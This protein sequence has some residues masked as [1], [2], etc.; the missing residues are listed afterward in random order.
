MLKSFADKFNLLIR[1]EI[2]ME[3]RSEKWEP[4]R[5]AAV[6]EGSV[7]TAVSY[8]FQTGSQFASQVTCLKP[9]HAQQQHWRNVKTAKWS[10]QVLC[11]S[12]NAVSP[13]I[14]TYL[15]PRV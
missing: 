12:T 15:L 13:T 1:S 6:H 10:I 9:I 3:Q 7:D 8:E 2:F 5:I 4:C 11:K 14:S